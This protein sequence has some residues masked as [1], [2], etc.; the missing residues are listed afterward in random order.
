M[1]PGVFLD[2]L[3]QGLL[4]VLLNA[5]TPGWLLGPHG[6]Y[7]GPE[8]LSYSLHTHTASALATEPSPQPPSEMCIHL[9]TA[10]MLGEARVVCS[11]TPKRI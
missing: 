3:R 8:D 7:T 2:H 4:L 5:E 1:M 11:T 9:S 10:E 6:S